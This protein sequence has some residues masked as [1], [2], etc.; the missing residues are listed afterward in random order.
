MTTLA[1]LVALID[2]EAYWKAQHTEHKL[3]KGLLALKQASGSLASLAME[4]ER[5][6]RPTVFYTPRPF[7]IEVCELIIAVNQ[8]DT[9]AS[10]LYAKIKFKIDLWNWEQKLALAIKSQDISGQSKAYLEL[11]L[12]HLQ[13]SAETRYQKAVDCFTQVITSGTPKDKPLAY[14]RRAELYLERGREDLALADLQ[15][16]CRL[17]PDNPRAQVEYGRVLITAG[18]HAEAEMAARQALSIDPNYASARSLLQTAQAPLRIHISDEVKVE[19]ESASKHQARDDLHADYGKQL[20]LASDRAGDAFRQLMKALSRCKNPR[21]TIDDLGELMCES[22][23]KTLLLKAPE[24]L[25]HEMPEHSL[26]L[27]ADYGGNPDI[28]SGQIQ[29]QATQS[30]E[31]CLILYLAAR[32]SSHTDHAVTFCRNISQLLAKKGYYYQDIAAKNTDNPIDALD[33]GIRASSYDSP[34]L[35]PYYQAGAYQIAVEYH[36][37]QGILLLQ[38][39]EQALKNLKTIRDADI[40]KAETFLTE[41]DLLLNMAKTGFRYPHPLM[42]LLQQ[43]RERYF[44]SPPLLEIFSAVFKFRLR[45]HQ[46]DLRLLQNECTP[47]LTR[48]DWWSQYALVNAREALRAFNDHLEQRLAQDPYYSAAQTQTN[49]LLLKFSQNQP[50]SETAFP[51]LPD[52]TNAV[53]ETRKRFSVM[54]SRVGQNLNTHSIET[55][56]KEISIEAKAILSILLSAIEAF[57]G[58]AP[59]GFSLLGLGSYS[60]GEMSLCSDIDFA[61]LVS[62]ESCVQHPYFKSFL[63]LLA[64]LRRGLPPNVLTIESKDLQTLFGQEKSLMHTPFEMISEHCPLYRD[65]ELKIQKDRLSNTESYSVRRAK[66]IYSSQTQPQE[67]KTLFEDY[68][69]ELSK[70]LQTRDE[71]ETPYYQRVGQVCFEEDFKKQSGS[72]LVDMQLGQNQSHS[73]NLKKTH[74]RPLILWL[75]DVATYFGIAENNSF[76]ILEALNKQS[77]IVPLVLQELNDALTY[78]HTLR[79]K[80]HH[81]WLT[82]PKPEGVSFDTWLQMPPD[83]DDA[84][85]ARDFYLDASQQNTLDAITRRIITPLTETISIFGAALAPQFDPIAFYFE[86]Q[87][88]LLQNLAA[89]DIREAHLTILPTLAE[90]ALTR[91]HLLRPSPAFRD[92]LPE[93]K[94][95]YLDAL[96]AALETMAQS[97]ALKETAE[98]KALIQTLWQTPTE[99]GFRAE[100]LKQ[101]R[102]WHQQLMRL[103]SVE[104]SVPASNTLTTLSFVEGN[105]LKHYALKPEIA[106]QLLTIQGAWQPKDAKIEGNHLV[107]RILNAAKTETLCWAKVYPEQPGIEWLMLHLDQR[108]GIYGIPCHTLVNLHHHGQNTAVLLSAHVPHPNLLT[109][110]EKNPQALSQLDPAHFFKTLI[111]VLLTNPEDDK[112]N[113]YFLAPGAEG[114]KLIRIDNER[115]FFKAES[116]GGLLAKAKLQVKTIIYCLDLLTEPFKRDNPR[117]DAAIQDFLKLKPYA[118][119]KNLLLELKKLQPLWQQLFSESDIKTH[120]E[121]QIPWLSLPVLY[122]PPELVKELSTRMESLQNLLALHPTIR[123]LELLETTQHTLAEHY[124]QGFK[125][126]QNQKYAT[127]LARFNLSPGQHYKQE[128]GRTVSMHGAK[129]V[130]NSLGLSQMP[131][132]SQVKLIWRG[133]MYAADGLLKQIEQWEQN[134][135]HEVYSGLTHPD[136]KMQEEARANWQQ[137][138]NR[139]RVILLNDFCAWVQKNPSANLLLQQSILSVLANTT[140]HTLDLSAF[141]E[142][143]ED[144]FLIPILKTGGVHLVALNLNNC[145]K[146]SESIPAAIAE[147]CPNLKILQLCNM[148]WKSF[149]TGLRGWSPIVLSKIERLEMQNCKALEYFIVETPQTDIHLQGC[150][151]LMHVQFSPDLSFAAA[152]QVRPG[153]YQY[154]LAKAYSLGTGVLKNPIEAYY[155]ARLS[156]EQKHPS[157]SLLC[158]ESAYAAAKS[159]LL[160][161][162][163]LRDINQAY[164]WA[165]LSREHQHPLSEMLCYALF[166]FYAVTPLN[167]RDE[168]VITEKAALSLVGESPFASIQTLKNVD[169]KTLE[170]GGI[171]E[172]INES[173]LSLLS[174]TPALN[175]S[176]THVNW[177]SN[178]TG[179]QDAKTMREA[180]KVNGTLGPDSTLE[181]LLRQCER[182]AALS[183]NAVPITYIGTSGL[184]SASP[185]ILPHLRSLTLKHLDQLTRFLLQTPQL[186]SLQ[187]VN[188]PLENISTILST[189]SCPAL[190]TL[191]LSTLSLKELGNP[192]A[193]LILPQ[194]TSLSLEDLP[195]LRYITLQAPQLRQLDM[196]SCD[197]LET[198]ETQSEPAR[199]LLDK[200][201]ALSTEDPKKSAEQLDSALSLEPNHILRLIEIEQSLT[202]ALPDYISHYLLIPPEPSILTPQ[203]RI[204]QK[205]GIQQLNTFLGLVAEGEQDKAEAL[206]QKYPALGLYAGNVTDLSKRTFKSITALQYALWALDWHMWTMLLKYIPAEAAAQQM[207]QS[208]QGL[209]VSKH[210]VTANWKNLIQALNQY[211]SEVRV[212]KSSSVYGQTWVKQVGGAQLLLP[213]H[214][215]NEYCHPTRP[216]HPVPD[217]TKLEPTGGW[218]CRA[219]DES[220]WFSASFGGGALGERFAVCRGSHTPRAAL[221]VW[222]MPD[223]YL[224]EAERDSTAVAALLKTRASQ[225]AAVVAQYSPQQKLSVRVIPG[226]RAVGSS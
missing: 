53:Q 27:Q 188:I 71:R 145:Q 126:Y 45:H 78:L 153:E 175:N 118:L 21:E 106:S 173:G 152:K 217:F 41:F 92:L 168:S 213:A 181:E 18:R 149:S 22:N 25:A 190:S 55:L 184:L 178:K 66:L 9:K 185:L 167:G 198:L 176:F 127:V 156:L 154:Q 147:Y 159:H 42:Q 171:L 121:N 134:R 75:L 7:V 29:G 73:L 98:L 117:V 219:T 102:A 6:R 138:P 77:R 67:S 96:E 113:D 196:R 72:E 207:A 79:L 204:A 194:L 38:S 54:L 166:N 12:L 208:E 172:N 19:A 97:G 52:L 63:S 218:R 225:R 76:A 36:Y 8:N 124:Q 101:E 186:S 197:A 111:R 201:I 169:V 170:L 105:S 47:L 100:S 5:S 115:A 35:L 57:L 224:S 85:F 177:Q 136:P 15:E 94:L 202:Q 150:P 83:E 108:L 158:K 128:G 142:S 24:Y 88:N 140:F 200:G 214:V 30:F 162:G 39:L 40:R 120:Y 104:V 86:Q 61:V 28:H 130:T 60:R 99:D 129:A 146:L 223:V 33:Y 144:K 81:A 131:S 10:A 64:H 135:A 226:L 87:F 62:D 107:Y 114:L 174:F 51:A 46:T 37:Q 191:S 133:K 160:S 222:I 205:Q 93:L 74:L 209:W 141:R 112:G 31:D 56:Q 32:L 103:I 116:S 180:E 49:W 125:S 80:L 20:L 195:Q 17:A 123:G 109:T 26:K 119:L 2:E 82:Q 14:R 206:L 216:F 189:T 165:R 59:C 220:E 89:K 68:Q 44:S 183:L 43:K 91:P 182:L 157:A 132:L 13:S 139:Q 16:S 90:I 11:G 193:P 3:S 221:C 122:V 65:A 203:F 70:Q 34:D 210:G 199:T 164:H 48:I 23:F 212:S 84:R 215:I 148:S 58:E 192:K 187:L 143:L 151:A 50:L 4:A 137:L 163:A 69:N 161:D 110:L 95:A 179:V 155:W 1:E 211:I